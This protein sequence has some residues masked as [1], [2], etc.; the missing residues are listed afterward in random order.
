MRGGH[1]LLKPWQKAAALVRSILQSGLT[2]AKLSLTICLGAAVSVMPIPWTTLICALLAARF[3][4]NQAAIQAVNYL[5]YP[6]QIALFVPFCRLGE[7]LYPWGP[8]VSVRLLS[9]ALHGQVG[10]AASQ[11]AWGCLRGVGAWLLIV[12]PLT[13]LVYP[14]LKRLLL[15]RK[16]ADEA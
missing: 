10:S 11:I 8:K 1:Y 15:R 5:C 16:R 6:L 9:E 4:L 13:W 2:P 7:A 14:F 12:P 3:R